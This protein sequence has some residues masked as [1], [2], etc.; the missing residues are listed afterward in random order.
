MATFSSV[1]ITADSSTYPVLL[2]NGN[3]VVST[4]PDSTGRHSATWEDPFPK[5][6]YLFA[7]VVGDLGSVKGKY[8]TSS[9]RDVHLEIFSEKENV[10]KLGYAMESL[11]NSMKWDEDKV[12]RGVA[13]AR[14]V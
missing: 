10:N 5:P 7:V 9:G 8:T 4:P 12:R 11:K 1:K 2:S 3:L 14:C 6:S 13:R